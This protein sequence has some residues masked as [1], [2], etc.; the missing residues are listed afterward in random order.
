MAEKSRQFENL[1]FSTGF[2]VSRYARFAD[3]KIKLDNVE[4]QKCLKKWSQRFKFRTFVTEEFKLSPVLDHCMGALYGRVARAAPKRE[5][6]V[7]D[8]LHLF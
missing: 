3:K 6:S 7:V 4:F 8:Q 2:L 5:R 1:N